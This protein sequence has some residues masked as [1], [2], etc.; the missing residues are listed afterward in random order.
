MIVAKTNPV[1]V[2]REIDR[3][4][5]SLDAKIDLGNWEIYGRA[6]IN[7]KGDVLIP[8]VYIGNGFEA[9]EVFFDDNF[10]TTSFFLSDSRIEM[11][12]GGYKSKRLIS[13]IIQT[14]ILK[15]FGSAPRDVPHR[16]D[17]ELINEMLLILQKHPGIE[18]LSIDTGIRDVYKEFDTEKIKY[19]DMSDFNVVRFNFNMTYTA[20]CCADC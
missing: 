14:K 4:Q 13:L 3:L 5:R 6:N 2:D 8:E 20:T 16:G 11:L 7:P 9:K 1:G 19:T 15:V 12:A 18:M 17:E 10:D